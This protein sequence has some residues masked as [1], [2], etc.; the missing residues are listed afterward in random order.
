MTE[1][2]NRFADPVGWLISQVRQ[3]GFEYIFKRYYG[4]YRAICIDTKDPENRGRVRLKCPSIGH[5]E[6]DD[7]PLDSWALPCMPGLSVGSKGGQMH[8]SFH[9][10]NVGD[11]LWVSYEGGR[12]ENAVYMGGWLPRNQFEGDDLIEE[13]ALRKGIRTAT[14]HYIRL[15]DVEDNLQ[16]TITKGDGKGGASG[17]FL[18]MSNEEEISIATAKGNLIHMSNDQTTVVAPDGANVA[19]GDGVAMVM[20]ADG[21]SFGLQD[22]VFQVQC[23]EVMLAA[24]KKITLKGNVDLGGG[25]VYE[26]VVMGQK[27]AIFH[28]THV[29]TSTMP[30]SPTTPQVG[31]PLV[32]QNGLSIK[33]RVS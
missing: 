31:P 16:I 26:P 6:D 18:T 1:R 27:M 24:T 19:L 33:V 10:P 5:I 13:S 23:D 32:P 2:Q 21:N 8:G 14:G 3:W 12:T 11:Q 7:V 15:I 25:P 4:L 30:G 17:T 20:D 29:H 28:A 9:P 22:G